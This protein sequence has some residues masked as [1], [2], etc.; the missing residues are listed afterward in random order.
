MSRDDIIPDAKAID[1]TGLLETVVWYDDACP[2]DLPP[3]EMTV[4]DL[5]PLAR[6]ADLALARM[7]R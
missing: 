7:A 4:D 5:G 1:S 6:R 3:E 2:L